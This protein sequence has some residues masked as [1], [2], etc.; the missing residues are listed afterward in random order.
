[1][2]FERMIEMKKIKT[3]E[4]DKKVE[5]L[6]E[7]LNINISN[8]LYEKSIFDYQNVPIWWEDGD[9]IEF[10][11][12][13][14]WNSTN[15]VFSTSVAFIKYC[16]NGVFKDGDYSLSVLDKLIDNEDEVKKI[17]S[18]CNQIDELLIEKDK[19]N[20]KRIEN[21]PI[22][23]QLQL[24]WLN[25]TPKQYENDLRS[26]FQNN[27]RCSNAIYIDAIVRPRSLSYY[28]DCKGSLAATRHSSYIDGKLKFIVS[29]PTANKKDVV[30]VI[31]D[32]LTVGEYLQWIGDNYKSQEF[33]TS[34]LDFKTDQP[35]WSVIDK[36]IS[37]VSAWY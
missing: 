29:Q 9:E 6:L 24:F 30:V 26:N 37:E 34:E 18:I 21:Q 15:N 5:E 12:E 11:I 25:M 3:I 32:D 2:K 36:D 1:M 35:L 16:D 31:S 22:E 23:T 33:G 4:I 7:K 17:K 28:C 13:T 10:E 27:N 19:L 20:T 14:T 8:M